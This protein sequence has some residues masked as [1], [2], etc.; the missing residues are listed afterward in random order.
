[1]PFGPGENFC[2]LRGGGKKKRFR[3]KH[4]E[5][6]GGKGGGALTFKAQKGLYHPQAHMTE[7]SYRKNDGDQKTQGKREGPA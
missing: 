2:L 7:R 6:A 1:L 5:K 3:W 4:P